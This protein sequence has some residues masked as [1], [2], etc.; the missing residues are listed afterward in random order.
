MLGAVIVLSVV[1]VVLAVLC[2]EFWLRRKDAITRYAW[3][4]IEE[5]RRHYQSVQ[6]DLRDAALGH[7]ARA[8]HHRERCRKLRRELR[9]LKRQGGSDA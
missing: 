5:I 9:E 1:V 6:E 8:N 4:S 3:D 7:M 2:H